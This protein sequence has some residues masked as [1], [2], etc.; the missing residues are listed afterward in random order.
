MEVDGLARRR[1]QLQLAGK[2]VRLQQ[3]ALLRIRPLVVEADLPQHIGVGEVVGQIRQSALG[4]LGRLLYDGGRMEAEGGHDG[5]RMAP[6]QSQNGL[7]GGD[8]LAHG[9]HP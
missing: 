9:H 7:H 3:L 5:G 1:G 2:G 8:V 6:A 4:L